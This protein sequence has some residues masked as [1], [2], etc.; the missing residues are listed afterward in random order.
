MAI[1]EYTIKTNIKSVKI[2]GM[3]PCKCG[4]TFDTLIHTKKKSNKI[5]GVSA[6]CNNIEC[7]N[8]KNGIL[9]GSESDLLYKIKK[10]F[11]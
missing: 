10:Y 2:E 9:G 11:S 5:E 7:E 1:F 6:S 4:G 8:H 3:P